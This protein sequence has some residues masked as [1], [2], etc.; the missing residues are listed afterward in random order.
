MWHPILGS[1]L[2][3]HIRACGKDTEWVIVPCPSGTDINFNGAHRVEGT[4]FNQWNMGGERE[5]ERETV[6]G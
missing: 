5:R 2:K 3:G 4:I 1:L 6:F